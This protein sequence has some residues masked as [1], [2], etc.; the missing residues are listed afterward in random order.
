M[1][2][3]DPVRDVNEVT[4]VVEVREA[5]LAFDCCRLFECDGSQTLCYLRQRPQFD[6]LV[7]LALAE[8][9][10]ASG[11]FMALYKGEPFTL[12]TKMEW[13]FSKAYMGFHRVEDT[14]SMT[15]KVNAAGDE[16]VASGKCV[17]R[18]YKAQSDPSSIPGSWGC[19]APGHTST[20]IAEDRG[21]RQ[22]SIAMLIRG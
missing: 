8:S 14:V 17:E 9:G 22:E 7:P 11:C 18:H 15:A 20:V 3:D 13:S 16:I 10:R 6:F 21:V 12:L 5:D 2:S 4:F 19:M 1:G